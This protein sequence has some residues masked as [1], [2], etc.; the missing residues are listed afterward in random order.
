[1]LAF[2]GHYIQ[3]INIFWY[4]KNSQHSMLANHYYNNTSIKKYKSE[5]LPTFML[6]LCAFVTSSL[7]GK[8]LMICFQSP[9]RIA[10]TF[11]RVSGKSLQFCVWCI[12][13]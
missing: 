3:L 6:E 1:M 5:I 9:R 13:G 4:K 12:N 2:H 7:N 11:V 10:N 8:H